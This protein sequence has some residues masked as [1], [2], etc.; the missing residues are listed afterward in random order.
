MT[1]QSDDTGP[2][3]FLGEDMESAVLSSL[4]SGRAALFSTRSTDKA[5]GKRNEDACGVFHI[6]G[7]AAVIAVAD[8]CGGMPRGGDAADLAIRSLESTLATVRDPEELR[9]AILNGFENADTAINALDI[10]AATTLV[11]AEIQDDTVRTYHVGDS[12]LMLVGNRG[13]VR[14][15]TIAH[16]PVGYAVEAGLLD[17]RRAMVHEDRNL[18][19]NLLGL[20]EMHIDIGSRVRM[21]LRDT[22]VLGSDGLFD[23]LRQREIVEFIRKGPLDTVARELQANCRRR[24]ITEGATLSKPDDLTFA[25]YRRL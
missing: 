2:R 24:M 12:G 5:P 3:L 8:G 9:P 25:V 23:N 13:K 19:S 6:A 22:L 17:E 18:V 16:S 20:G 4:G 10:G 21:Q 14:F 15:Q 11:V 7:Q 1:T